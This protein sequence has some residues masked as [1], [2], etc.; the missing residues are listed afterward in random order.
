MPFAIVSTGLPFI[1]QLLGS[2][3]PHSELTQLSYLYGTLGFQER[4]LEQLRK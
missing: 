2:A 3:F 4:S 1:H